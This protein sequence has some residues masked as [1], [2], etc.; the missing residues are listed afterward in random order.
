MVRRFLVSACSAL[1]VLV[2]S[3][4]HAQDSHK[5]EAKKL[6][7]AYK[8]PVYA[9]KGGVVG[10][11]VIENVNDVLHSHDATYEVHGDI[12]KAVEFFTKALGE[13]STKKNDTGTT[14]YTYTKR[15]P[16]EPMV[17]RKV[18]VL[19]DPDS[20]QVQVTLKMRT[21]A[22]KDDIIDEQ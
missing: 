1:T 12:K 13:P 18:I 22:T 2:A 3:S 8:L 16:D 11:E 9:P 10:G 4:A 14:V 7:A 21:Y 17:G 20:R 6:E 5:F 19:I 15:D